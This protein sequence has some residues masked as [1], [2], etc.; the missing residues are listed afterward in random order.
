MLE[1]DNISVGIQFTDVL[2]TDEKGSLSRPPTL[3]GMY[4]FGSASPQERSSMS[5]TST[6]DGHLNIP[7]NTRLTSPGNLPLLSTDSTGA[8]ES[9]PPR[10]L[11]RTSMALEMC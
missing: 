9:L 1:N 6:N 7:V 2:P 11:I 5:R 10:E 3:A 4:F 8:G